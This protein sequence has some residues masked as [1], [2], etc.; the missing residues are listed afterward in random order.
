MNNSNIR[1]TQERRIRMIH[2]LNLYI[3]RMK[4]IINSIPDD[5]PELRSNLGIEI[6][7][8]KMQIN[9]IEIRMD[10]EFEKQ[11]TNNQ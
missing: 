10:K 5:Q 9:E 6:N 4:V 1:I 7:E 2:A 3:L 8:A 11:I